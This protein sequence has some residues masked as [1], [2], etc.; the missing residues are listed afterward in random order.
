VCVCVC[1]ALGIQHAKRMRRIAICGLYGSTTFFYII[2]SEKFIEYKMCVLVP[3]QI[4]SETC[5][6]LR[7]TER[8]MIKNVYW[9]LCTVPAI[10][11]R[12]Q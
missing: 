4:L 6:I 2:S 9:S 8:D 11:V 10:L 12:F 3:L 5:L 7:R 1:V